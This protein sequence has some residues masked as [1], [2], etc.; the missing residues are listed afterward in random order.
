MNTNT[1]APERTDNRLAL[2]TI[3]AIRALAGQPARTSP[4]LRI[5]Q[6]MIDG[7]AEVTRDHQWIH[8]DAE[9]A[10]RELPSGRTIAHGFLS[11]SLLSHLVG[12]VFSYPGRQ[13]ALNYGF[14]RV[15]FTS[16]VPQGSRVR[17]TV[18]LGEAIEVGPGE[19]RV[20]WDVVLEIEGQSRP[21]LVARWLVQMR[22]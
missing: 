9:R 18:A 19:L 1:L 3:E 16:A 4:W 11:L 8:A 12:E 7:F 2:S 10:A 6:P 13:S 21:A 5:D 20:G 15:R 14:D 17:A 22:Y